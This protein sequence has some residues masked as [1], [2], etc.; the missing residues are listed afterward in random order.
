MTE[1]RRGVGLGLQTLPT[2]AETPPEHTLRKV[3]PAQTHGPLAAGLPLGFRAA[4]AA[5]AHVELG[6]VLGSPR[7]R[8]SEL[9][10]PPITRS[11]PALGEEISLGTELLV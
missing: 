7:R 8:K 6:C 1:A 5:R 11:F 4:L 9:I 3:P 10:Q 2:S